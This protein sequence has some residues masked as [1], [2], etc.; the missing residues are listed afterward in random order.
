MIRTFRPGD[1][2]ALRDIHLASITKVGPL[3][4][5]PA[6]V[7]AWATKTREASEWLEWHDYGDRITIAFAENG[8]PAAFTLLEADGH[9]DMLYCHPDHVRQGHALRLVEEASAFGRSQGLSTI[10]TDA[11][12]LAR[13]VFLA[14]GYQVDERQDF[15]LDG[16]P[17]HNY[18]MS[19]DLLQ[20]TELAA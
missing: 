20:E 11:S 2:H 19:K 18:A 13:P 14:A 17:I 12:E 16:V 4:Y 15:L 3:A 1:E 8:A 5:N 7:A 6:Q 9:L 10:T